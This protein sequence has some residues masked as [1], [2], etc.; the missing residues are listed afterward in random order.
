MRPILLRDNAQNDNLT[1]ELKDGEID[2]SEQDGN[3]QWIL[4]R[5][6]H[7]TLTF[8]ELLGIQGAGSEERRVAGS[9]N[10]GYHVELYDADTESKTE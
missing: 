9:V 4:H 2:L 10:H 8:V 7:A 3:L 5:W 1:M 6:W